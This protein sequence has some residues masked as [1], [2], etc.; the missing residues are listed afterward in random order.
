M[1]E[2][3]LQSITDMTM[4]VGGTVLSVLLPPTIMLLLL[5][6]FVPVI[7]SPLWQAWGRFVGWLILAPIR[8]IQYLIREAS[9]RRH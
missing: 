7:G 2:R 8:V 5:K 1:G 4:A 9:G 3:I 6:M